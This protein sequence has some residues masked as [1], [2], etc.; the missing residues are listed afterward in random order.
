MAA[1]RYPTAAT[2]RRLLLES[3][4]YWPHIAG[5][6]LLDILATPLS[7]LKP[8][9]LSIAIDS[10]IGSSPLPWHLGALLPRRVTGSPLWLLAFA[11]ILQVLVA[12]FTQLQTLGTYML[13]SQTGE[14]LT[15]G[16]RTRLFQ[17][18]QRLSL[19]FHDSRG[20]ADSLFRIEYDAPAINTIIIQGFIPFFAEFVLL[21]SMIYVIAR[22]DWWLALVALTIAPILFIAARLYDKRMGSQYE[23][24]QEL[25]SRALGVVQEALTAVRVVKAFGRENSEE[26]RFVRHS[27][28]GVRRKVRLAFAEGLFGSMVNVVTAA[29]T[30][31]VLFIGVLHVQSGILTLGALYMVITYLT[32]LYGPLER[33]SNQIASLQTSLISAKR[34]FEILDEAPE[35]VER[36][37]AR[38]LKRAT[39]AVELRDVSFGYDERNVI[40]DNVSFAVPAGARVGIAGR[41]GAGKSTLVSLL[42]RFYDP[43]AGEILVD[44][45]DLRDYKLADLRN[46]FALVLQDSVLFSTSIAEN[47]AYARPEA[48]EEEIR[49]AAMAARAHDFIE[50][51]P[52]GYQTQVGERGMMVSGGERQRISLARAFLKDAP[53]LILDEPTS[54]VDIET[55]GAILEAME[56]LMH[57]RTSFVISHRLSALEK[58]DLLLV[59]ENG[60][61][62]RVY[63][64]VSEALGTSLVSAARAS[65]LDAP[66]FDP[67]FDS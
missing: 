66:S 35:V 63:H 5:I 50:A 14:R 4:R 54:A 62:V 15:L 33:M 39:G 13:N 19:S 32:E 11:A 16:F 48:T 53:I 44:G 29:G 9:A 25:E 17:H 40:L 21:V 28:E 46:Q 51:L 27:S 36:P 56:R 1:D 7:L 57:G 58:S 26:E 24:V 45:L 61:G 49:A 18:I 47:I 43:S 22:L 6:I 10:V 60:R 67:P 65:M 30:G 52:D 41:T 64:D 34:A 2:V 20:T 12:F 8:L 38:P 42:T 31:L 37:N 59:F 23:A 55:E 3:R